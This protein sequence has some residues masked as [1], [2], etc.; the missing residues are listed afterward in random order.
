MADSAAQLHGVEDGGTAS[1]GFMLRGGA[2]GELDLAPYA[3][4]RGKSLL[5]IAAGRAA[6]LIPAPQ[7]AQG[8]LPSLAVI[9]VGV[10]IGVA[11]GL[12]IV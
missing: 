11:A 2:P 10:A 12:L 7:S 6:E 3:E 4:L 5:E 1:P 9:G 8:E